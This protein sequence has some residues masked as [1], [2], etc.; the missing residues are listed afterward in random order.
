MH[1]IICLSF[2]FCFVYVLFIFSFCY[3]FVTVCLICAFWCVCLYFFFC[4]L[5][6]FNIYICVYISEESK[7]THRFSV[8][9]SSQSNRESMRPLWFFHLYI[10]SS[11]TTA[12]ST[13]CQGRLYPHIYICVYIYLY[14]FFFGLSACFRHCLRTQSVRHGIL[15]AI[16]PLLN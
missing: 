13:L 1:T 12:L 4:S 7:R 11:A 8:T 15:G 6:F 10:H 3:D 9:L 5:V 2:S 14:M 16:R